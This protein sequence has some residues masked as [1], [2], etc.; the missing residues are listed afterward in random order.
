M[1]RI[2]L[3]L[4]EDSARDAELLLLSLARQGVD[5]ESQ[6][7]QSQAGLEAALNERAWDVVVSDYNLPGFDGLQALHVVRAH[8][9]DLPFLLVSGQVGEEMAVLAMRSGAS[10][11]L[12]KDH[13][14]RLG[15]AIE[16]ELREAENHRIQ[17]A[18]EL[19]LRR[20]HMAISQAPDG[21][22]ITNPEGDIVFANPAMERISGYPVQELLGQNP[23]LFK[24]DRQDTN[25]YRELWETLVRGETWRGIFQNQRQDGTLWQAEASIAPVLDPAGKLAC[26][27]CT[28]RDVTHERLLQSQLEQSQRLEAIG[29]LSAGIAHDFNNILMPILAHAELGL[30]RAGLSAELRRDLE[31][32]ELSAQRAAMLTRQ[33]LGYTRGHAAT[34]QILDLTTLV[35]ESLKLLRAA[36]PTTVQFQVDLQGSGHFVLGDPTQLHQ[37]LLNLC[38]NAAHAMRHGGG[39]LSLALHRESL[40][41][42][43]CAL[44]LP[45]PQGDYVILQV[46]DTG[47]GMDEATLGR[48]FLPFFTTKG[49]GEGTGLG[50]PIVLGILQDLKGGLQVT[51]EPGKGTQFR[52]LLPA[53]LPAAAPSL[54]QNGHLPRGSER[55]LL[56]DDEVTLITAVQKL[57]E[58]L[59][60]GVTPFISPLE[61]LHHFETRPQAFDLLLTDLTMPGMTGLALIAKFRALRKDL[62]VLLMTGLPNLDL[63][64]E[65][66]EAA[67]DGSLTKPFTL[68]DLAWTVRAVL[69]QRR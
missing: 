29:V 44:G 50:L 58:G 2:H 43:R 69:D 6:R 1:N 35:K 45:V 63:G 49:P 7:V 55:I 46:G 40:P 10:D 3:L 66:P 65:G 56:V 27:V 31:I 4:I 39:I 9:L 41:E 16:R 47:C 21:I 53:A 12:T 19:E 11:F 52:I 48:I 68:R 60:Y 28:Q 30:E 57:L 23:R 14:D 15:P 67:P 59:G 37:I 18:R 54:E 17:R 8:D 34:L 51:S 25:F 26:Y 22:V 13:L 32:I 38:S 62:P 20:L 64:G 61:A 24:S 5:C 36:I 42:T 33:V